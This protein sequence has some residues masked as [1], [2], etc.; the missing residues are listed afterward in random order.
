MCLFQDA[1]ALIRLDDLFLESFEVSDGTII[2]KYLYLSYLGLCIIKV[3]VIV[4]LQW[5]V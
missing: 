5:N 4:F 1:L 3:Y 2:S